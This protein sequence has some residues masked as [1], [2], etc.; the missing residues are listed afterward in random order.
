MEWDE[1]SNGPHSYLDVDGETY[2]ICH[3]VHSASYIYAHETI[4]VEALP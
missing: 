3:R 4:N 1:A 2:A